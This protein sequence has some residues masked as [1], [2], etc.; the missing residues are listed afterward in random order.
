MHAHACCG[1]ECALCAHV[2]F[3]QRI[4]AA[5]PRLQVHGPASDTLNRSYAFFHNRPAD[6][7]AAQGANSSFRRP[8]ESRQK[9]PMEESH[10]FE[11]LGEAFWPRSR[12][13]LNP[14]KAGESIW[15]WC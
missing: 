15:A 1:A 4:P 12:L 7:V 14:A 8:S 13:L 10:G 11:Y 9:A 5:A 2:L 3:L 6:Q